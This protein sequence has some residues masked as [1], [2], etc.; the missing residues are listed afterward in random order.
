MLPPG[1]LRRP[2]HVPDRG[3]LFFFLPFCSS[4][5]RSPTFFFLEF[6]PP[7]PSNSPFSLQNPLSRCFFFFFVRDFF[8]WVRSPERGPSPSSS[9]TRKNY[10]APFFGRFPS[11]FTPVSPF[12]SPFF[13]ICGLLFFYVLTP[14][15]WN[16][17]VFP[18]LRKGFTYRPS[19]SGPDWS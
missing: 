18:F 7:V 15:P 4:T 8:D 3:P 1:P 11:P 10:F 14:P 19:S 12:F 6:P 16:S 13:F 2:C 9:T 5:G 17:P